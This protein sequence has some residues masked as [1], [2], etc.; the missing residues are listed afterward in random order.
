VLRIWTNQLT[1]CFERA[2][3]LLFPGCGLVV[4]RFREGALSFVDD[5]HAIEGGGELNGVL[6]IRPRV[7][8]H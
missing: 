1:D 8:D 4:G 2:G 5:G 6:E 7:D 3:P